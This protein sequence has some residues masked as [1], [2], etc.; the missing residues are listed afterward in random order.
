MFVNLYPFAQTVA[1]PNVTLEDAIENIDIGGPAMVRSAAKNHNGV[2][3]VVDPADYGVITDEILVGGGITLATRKRLA[4]KAFAHTATYDAGIADYLEK[5]YLEPESYGERPGETL[6]APVLPQT[7]RIQIPRVQILRYGENPHQQ[8]AFY[9]D[10]TIVEPCI[11]NAVRRDR[12][13][14]E[15]SFNNLYDLN[16]ALELVKEFSRPAVAI[17]QARQPVRMRVAR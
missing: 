14:K 10:N 5:T 3:I 17:I 12:S 13:N 1:K 11:G 8:G 2:A 7:L 9:R 6:P 16:A 15:V 4:A